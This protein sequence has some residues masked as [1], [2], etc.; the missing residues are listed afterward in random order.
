MR[1]VL[2]YL[3]ARVADKSRIDPGRPFHNYIATE[4]LL[5]V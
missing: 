4:N 3:M 2:I 1:I 5:A